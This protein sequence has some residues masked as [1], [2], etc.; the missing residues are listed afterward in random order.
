MGKN[1]Y[2][3]ASG[4]TAKEQQAVDL[5]TQGNNRIETAAIMGINRDTLSYHLRAAS[6]KTGMPRFLRVNAAK[7]KEAQ[8]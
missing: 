2:G 4:L 6:H 3:S 5:M 8:V 7:T 1:Q